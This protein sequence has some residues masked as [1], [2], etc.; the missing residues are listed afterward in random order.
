MYFLRKW[1][2]ECVVPYNQIR[3]SVTIRKVFPTVSVLNFRVI[4]QLYDLHRLVSDYLKALEL[5][6][7]E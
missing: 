4:W 7:N 2:L 3:N 5:R 1:P 6:F